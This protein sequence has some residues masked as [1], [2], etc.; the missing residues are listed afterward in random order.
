MYIVSKGNWCG[1][2]CTSTRHAVHAMVTEMGEN[3]NYRQLPFDAV[4][5][6]STWLLDAVLDDS[7]CLFDPDLDKLD[8][9]LD[10]V[11]DNLVMIK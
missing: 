1:V 3:S 10:Q 8:I 2:A 11:L 6:N 4:L 5:D 7:T 9:V